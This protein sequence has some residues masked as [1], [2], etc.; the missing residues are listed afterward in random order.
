MLLCNELLQALQLQLFHWLQHPSAGP[1]MSATR[2]WQVCVSILEKTLRCLLSVF[3]FDCF[4]GCFVVK[5]QWSRQCHSVCLACWHTAGCLHHYGLVVSGNM[6]WCLEAVPYSFGICC[7]PCATK[8]FTCCIHSSLA[9]VNL[10]TLPPTHVLRRAHLWW[11]WMCTHV[12]PVSYRGTAQPAVH[13][14]SVFQWTGVE[15]TFVF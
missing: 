6:A 14:V 11:L 4:H 13:K 3:P 12:Q 1:H 9:C 5:L 2:L 15:G 10:C 8:S 7:H